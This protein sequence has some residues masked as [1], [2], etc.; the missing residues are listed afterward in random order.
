MPAKRPARVLVV[1]DEPAIR[2]LLTDALSYGDLVVHAAASGKEAID[3]AKHSPP[4]I[5]VTDLCLT[6]CS[7]LDVIDHVRNLMGDVPAV[8]ITG[9]GDPG[10]LTEASR[11]RP[12]ELMSKPLNVERLRDTI[13]EELARR[14]RTKRLERQALRLRRVARDINGQKRS[15]HHELTTTCVNLTSAYRTLSG[16]MALQKTVIC[17]QSD[18]V[19]A[20]DDDDVFRSAFRLFVKRS[21][22]LFG[23]AMVCDA[24]AR[25]K[26]VG[27]FGVPTPDNL[28]FC[29][30]LCEP[31][32][33]AV[34]T[35]PQCTL[36]DAGEEGGLFDE[37]IRKY[38]VGLTVLA[39]PLIPAPGEMIGLVLLYR[40]GEQPFTDADVALAE[41]VA[42]STALAVQRND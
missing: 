34:L 15:I 30:H 27:R 12:V 39:V 2:E 31:L 22:P 7:G 26:I 5:L 25:L 41:L 20:K 4:D 1:D 18:L 37:S 33:D 35:H 40:K 9:R 6:D 8:V 23:V 19:R 38:L 13:R 42:H 21:G 3:L 29:Q 28:A 17:Y 24:E 10:A 32:I 11:R 14:A 16:Q 36:M